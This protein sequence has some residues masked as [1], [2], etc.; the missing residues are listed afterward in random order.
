MTNY[1]L[2]EGFWDKVNRRGRCWIWTRCLGNGYGYVGF[3]GRT[4]KAS[5]LVLR[6]YTGESG[7][8]LDAAHGPC[9]N[10]ACVHPLHLSWK[11]RK[12][13]MADMARDGTSTRGERSGTALLTRAQ[14]RV[15]RR[16]TRVQRVVAKSYGVS[17][18]TVSLIKSGRRW[19]WLG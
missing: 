7:D 6:W 12:E 13:N 17:Q 18:A 15:I 10:R 19:A 1:P 16:D 14:V 11:T 2:P 8:G 3:E 9:N 5:R 4:R